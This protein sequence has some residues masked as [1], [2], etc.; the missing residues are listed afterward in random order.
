VVN[1]ELLRIP[2]ADSIEYDLGSRV[3]NVRT[4]SLPVAAFPAGAEDVAYTYSLFFGRQTTSELSLSQQDLLQRLRF[5]LD[6]ARRTQT[7]L[8]EEVNFTFD[9]KTG[10]LRTSTVLPGDQTLLVEIEVN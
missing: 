3:I 2:V 1:R 4:V 5:M 8:L 7:K 6:Y 10:R 9:K